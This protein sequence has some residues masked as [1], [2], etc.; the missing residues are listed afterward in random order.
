MKVYQRSILQ[1][2]ID[3]DDLSKPSKYVEK[4]RFDSLVNKLNNYLACDALS[5]NFNLSDLNIILHTDIFPDINIFDEIEKYIF[6][7]DSPMCKTVC[8]AYTS[9][10]DAYTVYMLAILNEHGKDRILLRQTDEYLYVIEKSKECGR[11]D[12]LRFMIYAPS[13]QIKLSQLIAQIIGF[14]ELLETEVLKFLEKVFKSEDENEYQ[15][16]S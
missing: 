2:C 15:S 12:E 4:R 8:D 10:H 9:K 11:Y 13:E 1:S 6:K 5:L 3:L 16:Y 7:L 14:D